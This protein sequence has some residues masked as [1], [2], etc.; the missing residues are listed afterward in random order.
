VLSFSNLEVEL[1][2]DER[3][4]LRASPTHG[5]V[6][7]FSTSGY[8]AMCDLLYE[9]FHSGASIILYRMGEGYARKLV[10]SMPLDNVSREEALDIFQKLAMMAGW[11]T[12]NLRI[13]DE[14]TAECLATDSPF[15]LHRNDVGHVSCFYLSGVLS[16]IASALF[17]SKF[18]ALEVSCRTSGSPMCRFTISQLRDSA[19]SS[20]QG[21]LACL[22]GNG[23]RF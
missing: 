20:E 15:V 14:R 9:Q 1:V 16:G 7:L 21:F 11:G 19:S 12:M 22:R 10:E 4:I 13:L 17:K 8:R 23:C 5:R 18:A 3:G 6:I 2:K